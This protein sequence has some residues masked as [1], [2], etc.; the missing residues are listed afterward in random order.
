MSIASVFGFNPKPKVMVFFTTYRCNSRCIMCHIWEK[1]KDSPELS[2]GQIGRLFGDRL[3]NSNLE[4]VNITGGEPTL[5]RDLTE[6][7]KVLIG[8]C[9]RLRRI[10]I[11]TNGINSECVIDQIERILA[12]LNPTPVK[13]SVTVSM[14]GT[15]K[16]Y[17]EVRGVPDIFNKADKTLSELKKLG[18]LYPYLSLGINTTFSKVNIGGLEDIRAYAKRKGVGINFTP[19]AISEIGVESGKKQELFEMWSEEK[20][21]AIRFFEKLVGAG[22][23]DPEYARFV[24]N[25]L[26]GGKRN[27]GCTFRRGEAF[28]LEPSGDIYLCGNF[29]EFFIGNI[30]EDKFSDCWVKVKKIPKSLWKYCETCVSNCYLDEA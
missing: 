6:I 22:E 14:D 3:L 19:A 25:W 10:D 9:K 1:Q 28:L 29:K 24:I 26:R 18:K 23:V 30:I 7:V 21:E 27:A 5:R 12:I 2:L 13:L 8:T 11:P 4:I 15:G 20:G 17:E 16:V